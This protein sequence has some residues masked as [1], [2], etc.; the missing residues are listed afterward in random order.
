NVSGS[1]FFSSKSI[2]RNLNGFQDSLKEN[3]YSYPSLL[4]AMHWKDAVPPL[5]PQDLRA[6]KRNDGVRLQWDFPQ[7]ANDGDGAYR[8][9]VYRSFS[10][11]DLAITDATELFCIM[12]ASSDTLVDGFPAASGT[13][14]WYVTTSLDRLWNESAPSNVSAVRFF[15]SRQSERAPLQNFAA[16]SVS[17]LSPASVDVSL[18]T[19][20]IVVLKLYDWFGRRVST[21]FASQLNAGRHA[22]YFPQLPLPNGLY[23]YHLQTPRGMSVGTVIVHH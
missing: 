5:P 13:E 16:A 20:S 3:F 7:Y 22:L 19:P 10:Q 1:I 9:A 12:P 2:T 11:S 18:Q 17:A 15:N 8:F 23:A 14:L 4:P 6:V 21:V